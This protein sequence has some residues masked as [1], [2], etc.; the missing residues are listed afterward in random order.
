MPAQKS[1]RLQNCSPKS[2][3][4]SQKSF[5]Y[6]SSREENAQYVP[7]IHA[8]VQKDVR[9]NQELKDRCYYFLSKASKRGRIRTFVYR[10]LP[11][12]G[13]G[14]RDMGVQD[15]TKDRRHPGRP[16]WEAGELKD[17][18]N[19]NRY[20]VPLLWNGKAKVCYGKR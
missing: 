19:K 12:G 15:Q 6:V 8:D 16:H 9:V 20:G 1:Y 4:G 7:V 18:D 3:L 13:G 2:R 10:E 17:I 11:K 14:K 5:R